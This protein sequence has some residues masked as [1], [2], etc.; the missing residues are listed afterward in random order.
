VKT[1]QERP[2]CRE[3]HQRPPFDSP[4]KA[5]RVAPRAPLQPQRKGESRNLDSGCGAHGVQCP[6]ITPFEKHTPGTATNGP[7]A[8]TARP[9]SQSGLL[10]EIVRSFRLELPPLI[11]LAGVLL[12][13]AAPVRA[14]AQHAYPFQ[15][16]EL[17]MEER[18]TNA[19]S[20]LTLDEKVDLLRFR[21]G[22]S[23]LGI[24]PL[25]SVEG[26]HGEAMGGPGNWGRRSPHATTIFPQAIGMAET[27]DT[28]VMH[29]AGAVE[30]YEARYLYQNTNLHRGGL[31]VFAPNADLGRDPRWGRTEECYGEDPFFN[32]TMAAAFIKGLQ[33]DD[34]KY[35]QVASLLKHFFANSNEDGRGGSSSDFDE[36][37]FRE[38][39]SVPFRMGFEQGGARCFMAAYNA[40][41]RIPCTIQ[42]VLKDVAMK[43]WG[44][45][46]AICT[47]AGALRNLV[48]Q[49]H[50]FTT[51][52]QAAAACLKAGISQFLD[53]YRASLTNALADRLISE[54]DID[55][56]IARTLRIA[57]RLGLLDPPTN[58][59]YAAIGQASEPEPW[60]TDKH[61]RIAR[62]VTQKS[63]VL[64]KNS[65][66]LLPL[67]RTKLRSIAVIGPR[68]N[69]VLLD[70]YSG[71]PPYTVTPLAGIRNK[72]G[73]DVAVSFATNNDLGEAVKLARSA[74]VAVVCIGNNPLGGYNMPWAT[75]SVP[76]E[77]RE[78]IDR[79]SISL[80]QEDL[81]RQVYA[82]NPRTIV[83]LISSFPYAINWT[84]RHVPAIVHMTHCSEELGN[85]LGDVLFGDFNPAGRLVQTWP[86]S[87]DQLPPMMDYDIRHGRTYLYFKGKPL[88][89]FGFGLSYTVFDYS[90][91][92]ASSARLP[93]DGQITVS[94]DVK[95]AGSRAGEEVVQLYVK[96][97]KSRI[98]RP[99]KELR[100][101]RRI[102]LEPGETKTVNL[103]LSAA[104]L[105]CWDADKHAFAVERDSLQIL[106]GGSSADLRLEKTISV[107]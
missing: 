101:F 82:A 6:A 70:W 75:V 83:V 42:P 37:L 12:V 8:V 69:E 50:Y 67:N 5:G 24:P 86:K 49:H 99:L 2:G 21:A 10:T 59:P 64:L 80:E 66:H 30:G 56:V 68:A 105:A 20:L 35:W 45:D 63:I 57:I 36:Q 33:G 76:S 23:R 60:T 77:G 89:P 14:A 93:N 44:V 38:Y 97:L 43:E 88:Y 95:N 94:V 90:N 47:D 1:I 13:V 34:P 46:G 96:H 51:T 15:D 102:A 79:K 104:S 11:L 19:I 32:G 91:L 84:Q 107:E 71:L 74:E 29:Q 48:T 53:N 73:P 85:A 58:V 22:V 61:E 92:R 81:I 55:Q 31:V 25:S 16:P 9:D 62:L 54:S 106:V 41:N 4:Q 40:W 98:Q 28:D 18:I 27:W 103:P 78:G 100:G 17:P 39:Y 65:K 3:K 26:L 7:R 52:N 72:L 87:L